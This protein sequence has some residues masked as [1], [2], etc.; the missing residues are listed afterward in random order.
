MLIAF[1]QLS[2]SFTHLQSS[3]K[4][5]ERTNV[6][7][8]LRHLLI[9]AST[10]ACISAAPTPVD[11]ELTADIDK[12]QVTC[13][14]GVVVYLVRGSDPGQRTTGYNPRYSILPTAMESAAAAATNAAGGGRINRLNYPAIYGESPDY[15]ASVNQGIETLQDLAMRYV[16]ACPNQGRIVFMGYSQGA[17]VVTGALAGSQTRGP[18]DL[19]LRCKSSHYVPSYD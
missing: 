2:T 16:N 11:N 3:S 9:L 19:N 1:R 13:V 15:Q 14:N 18:I 10:A 8:R 4:I 17:Q 12:R 7:M 6:S 5:S